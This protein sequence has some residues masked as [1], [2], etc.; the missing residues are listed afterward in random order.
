MDQPPEGKLIPVTPKWPLEDGLP[1]FYANQYAIF[2]TENEVVLIFGSFMPTG[3]VLRSREEIENY[4]ES[5]EVKPLVKVVMSHG[6][7][8]A[9]AGLIKQKLEQ[10]GESPHD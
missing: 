6:G 4:L 5:A 1:L 10:K 9:L 2:E 7:W 8:N 3:F